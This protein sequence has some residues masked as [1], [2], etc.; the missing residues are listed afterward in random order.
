[1]H[2]KTLIALIQEG[3][4]VADA[5]LPQRF[6]QKCTPCTILRSPFLVKDLKKLF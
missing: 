1:M 2:N 3:G 5:S 4:W 6:E